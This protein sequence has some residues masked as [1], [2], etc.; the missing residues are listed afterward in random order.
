MKFSEN[1]IQAIKLF[2]TIN[3]SMVLEEGEKRLSV[4]S[5]SHTVIATTPLDDEFP[6]TFRL[7]NASRFINF[8]YMEGE[9]PE[10]QFMESLSGGPSTLK[11]IYPSGDTGHYTSA[12][13]RVVESVPHEIEMESIDVTF[14]L[15][16]QHVQKITKAASVLGVD[17]VS[18]VSDG[19]HIHVVVSDVENQTSD[20]VKIRVGECNSVFNLIYRSSYFKLVPDDY[21][22]VIDYTERSCIHFKG[23]S[24]IEYYVSLD[25][26]STYE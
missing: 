19:E 22:V 10:L 1:T 24:G 2:S 5:P 17:F 12:G 13:S 9:S 23:A 26:D 4:A 6:V 3:N 7:S 11:V 18:I 20:A 14:D 21:S 16:R 25:A 15:T 8:L